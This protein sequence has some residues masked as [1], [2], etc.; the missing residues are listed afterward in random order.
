M[1]RLYSPR[2][3]VALILGYLTLHCRRRLDGTAEFL[4][5]FTHRWPDFVLLLLLASAPAHA[6]VTVRYS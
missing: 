1:T 6:N 2:F 4:P 5:L 3:F